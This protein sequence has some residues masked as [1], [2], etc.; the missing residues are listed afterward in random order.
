MKLYINGSGNKSWF[1][2]IL[3]LLQIL[4]K[5]E[6]HLQWMEDEIF[7]ALEMALVKIF[8]GVIQV[9]K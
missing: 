1:Y 7:S 5:L 3:S 2:F 4:K 9:L 6:D 8:K